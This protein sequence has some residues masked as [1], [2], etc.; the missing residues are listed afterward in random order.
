MEDFTA[1]AFGNARAS[2]LITPTGT[3]LSVTDP[4]QQRRYIRRRSDS[5]AGGLIPVTG[6]SLSESWTYAYDAV[7][8]ITGI[9]KPGG[10]ES[11][12]YDD[13]D[14]LDT[15]TLPGSSPVTYSYDA[16]GNRLSETESGVTQ[17]S[18]YGT[19]SNRH[20]TQAGSALTYDANGN[21]LTDQ[22]G[23]RT[24]TYNQ[25]N[26]M[27]S[28]A[29]GTGTLGSYRYNALG[30]RVNKVAG[31]LDVDYVYGL[32]GQ[33]IG[34]YIN[35]ALL[36]EYVHLAGMPVAQIESG[37]VMYLHTDHLG[38]PRE[39]TDTNGQMVWRWESDPFGEAVANED[40]DGDANLVTVNLR[41]PG[42][43]A[44][45]ET[46]LNYNYFR[47][48]DPSTGRYTQSDPIGL[49]GG[50]NSYLYVDAN[51]L[52]YFD[53]LGLDKR[54]YDHFHGDIAGKDFTGQSKAFDPSTNDA[55][56][57]CVA[58]YVMGKIVPGVAVVYAM[59]K[60]AHATG[61]KLLTTVVKLGGLAFHVY[62][63]TQFNR[64]VADGKEA[65]SCS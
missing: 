47:T 23:S 24:F 46:G 4:V 64:I 60:G 3:T 44:D 49:E 9:T 38:T 36:K 14:R 17:N 57:T 52:R 7:S 41:F 26:R 2:A 65:C 19:S 54:S 16:V 28:V 61:K 63:L 25:R 58:N 48:Y 20:L 6:G 40:P 10:A 8:N 32:Q 29:D 42:Q 34:E 59:E 12:G 56:A 62:E 51:P 15:Y 18:T 1:S 11:Y 50:L 35:G 45:G 43:Y 37:N 33:L 5:A 21:R 22:G 39:A 13:L 31:A 55:G 53:S 27:A 30:Q